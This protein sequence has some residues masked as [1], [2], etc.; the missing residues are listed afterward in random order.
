MVSLGEEA[1]ATCRVQ[2]GVGLLRRG[3]GGHLRSGNGWHFAA[4]TCKLH[5]SPRQGLALHDSFLREHCRSLCRIISHWDSFHR[6]SAP[7]PAAVRWAL[8]MFCLSRL[9]SVCGSSA[10][11]RAG[12]PPGNTLTRQE[13]DALRFFPDKL[14][15]PCQEPQAWE[16]LEEAHATTKWARR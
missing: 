11:S 15:K 2:A 6:R 8:G 10:W 16:D 4:R 7:A 5:W 3:C 12:Q 1:C 9:S 13:A 14:M